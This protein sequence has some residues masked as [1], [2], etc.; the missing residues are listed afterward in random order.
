MMDAEL[1]AIARYFGLDPA[2]LD[3]VERA[4]G[5]IVK[6][7]Q[8][9]IPSVS[10]RSDALT[11]TARSCVHAMVDWVKAGGE[12]RQDSFIAFWGARWAPVGA[13]ND[14]T[15]LNTN[16][17]ANVDRLWTPTSGEKKA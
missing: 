6:A 3:A 5:N 14:P 17:A 11:I 15:N 9:S 7:V 1:K 13:T 10:S 12:E 16:W 4:E 8:C 2:L